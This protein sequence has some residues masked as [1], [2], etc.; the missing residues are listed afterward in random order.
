M[1]LHLQFE[2][3]VTPTA[4][5]FAVV[6]QRG[7]KATISLRTFV[8]GEIKNLNVSKPVKSS[9]LQRIASIF[10]TPD[11]FLWVLKVSSVVI[12]DFLSFP[13]SLIY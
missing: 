12:N 8:A 9:R 5:A 2:E 1:C 11:S 13:T 6:E 10:S 7:G 4:Y 3:G